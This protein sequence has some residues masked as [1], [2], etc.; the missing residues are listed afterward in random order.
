MPRENSLGPSAYEPWRH[1]H[2]GCRARS[3]RGADD[4][5]QR[6][7]QSNPDAASNHRI[8]S[9]PLWVSTPAVSLLPDRLNCVRWAA[10]GAHRQSLGASFANFTRGRY[11]LRESYRQAGVA[12]GTSLLAPAYHCRTMLDPALALGGDVAL[13]PLSKALTPAFAAIREMHRTAT[14]R[15]RPCSSRTFSAFPSRW[16]KSPHGAPR[17]TSP[18]SRTVR[19]PCSD[20]TIARRGSP[21]TGGF[22]VSSPYKFLTAPD[23]GL[24]WDRFGATNASPAARDRQAT[25]C[26]R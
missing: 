12:S 3:S 19:T 16:T 23:G 11:A 5:L 18:W 17:T 9:E 10:H 20:H 21:C 1:R 26:A 7:G 15:S 8:R 25:N 14:S 6:N 13:Y 4:A 22:V 2:A 24:L